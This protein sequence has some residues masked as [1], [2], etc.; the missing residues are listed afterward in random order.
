MKTVAEELI[1][2][3]EAGE[4][5]VDE[6]LVMFDKLTVVIINLMHGMPGN[7]DE[8]RDLQLFDTLIIFLHKRKNTKIYN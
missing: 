1:R 3:S 4:M 2:K 6:L 5:N 7:Q 8:L